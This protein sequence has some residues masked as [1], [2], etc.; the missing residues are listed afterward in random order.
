LTKTL[1]CLPSKISNF[2]CFSSLTLFS[3][4]LYIK[5]ISIAFPD[6]MFDDYPRLQLRMNGRS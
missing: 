3:F 2:L 4:V 6:F 1:S 5:I